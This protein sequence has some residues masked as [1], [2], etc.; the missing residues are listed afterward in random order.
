MCVQGVLA[1]D[2]HHLAFT[3]VHCQLPHVCPPEESV[4]VIL[5]GQAVLI[6]CHFLGDCTVVGEEACTGG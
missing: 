5:E 2:T 1:R 3:G 4:K 6:S